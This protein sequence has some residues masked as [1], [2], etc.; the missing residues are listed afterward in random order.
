MASTRVNGFKPGVY[1]PG[2]SDGVAVRVLHHQQQAQRK[3]KAQYT[4][5]CV[6]PVARGPFRE[7]LTE[8]GINF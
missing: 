3:T 7:K 1:L 5:L 2:F 8:R 6:L 4:G